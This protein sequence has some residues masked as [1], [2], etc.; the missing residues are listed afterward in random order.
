[1]YYIYMHYIYI[2]T[3]YMYYIYIH[4]LY[5]YMYYIYICLY[6]YIYLFMLS[7]CLSFVSQLR[8]QRL[9]LPHGWGVSGGTQK[10][11][12]KPWV[13]EVYGLFSSGTFDFFGGFNEVS[14]KKAKVGDE[15]FARQGSSGR[16][17]V[18]FL[19]WFL[20]PKNLN[21]RTPNGR[22]HINQWWNRKKFRCRGAAPSA[23]LVAKAGGETPWC[24]AWLGVEH[25]AY[26][27]KSNGDMM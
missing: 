8:S 7:T 3:I 21:I 16:W 18:I 5:I 23:L 22:S 13:L 1:M 14:Q 9:V 24:L 20:S 17:L 6:I 11:Q 10:S 25:G 12:Q 2:C 19:R 15:F 26:N 4:V 27:Q